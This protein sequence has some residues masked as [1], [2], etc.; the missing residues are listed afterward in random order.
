MKL[1]TALAPFALISSA[2]A[3][4]ACSYHSVE[5]LREGPTQFSLAPAGYSAISTIESGAAAVTV[6]PG[7]VT[8]PTITS[9]K[10][11]TTGQK[12]SSTNAQING[13][14]S[15]IT[16]DVDTVAFD[17]SYAYAHTS[18]VP[19]HNVGPFT[20]NPAYPSN[21]NRTVRIPLNP[22][23]AQTKT[24]TGLGN[25]GIMVNGAAFFNPRD[26]VSYNNQ[27]IWHQNANVIEAPSFDTAKGH[28]AP[29]MQ[30]PQPGQLVPGNYHYHQAPL[31]LLNQLDPGNTGQHHSPILGFAFDGYPIYGPYGYANADGTGGVIRETSGYGL[32]DITQRHTLADGTVLAST[33]WG[34]DVS[35]TS[36]GSYIEDYTFLGNS[37]LD[38]Y[39]G[40]FVVT[41]EYPGGTYAYFLT[42]DITGTSV[43]PY[44]VGPSY[45]GIV[46]TANLQGG[47]VSIPAN[48]TFFTV[49]EPTL[50]SAATMVAGITFLRRKR[51]TV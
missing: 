42:T 24:A 15:S 1:A 21:Q 39:N 22:Q 17:N 32:R 7:Q 5:P 26:A 8:N 27:N 14:V 35:A 19:S 4:L 40:R 47:S 11:N 10:L 45:Y 49:P 12:A 20:G 3:A 38:Q 31:A 48:A 34:P 44:I 28:P 18:G 46:D 51:S 43:Y 37:T 23:V 29:G 13:Y 6:Y 36:L 41:P 50:L 9:W 25:I 16:A 2:A 30:Q 33:Q